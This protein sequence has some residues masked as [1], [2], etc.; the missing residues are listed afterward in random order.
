MFV[1]VSSAPAQ[2]W[3]WN[4]NTAEFLW[5]PAGDPPLP[6]AATSV[7][8]TQNLH[9][10][11]PGCK[12]VGVWGRHAVGLTWSTLRQPVEVLAICTC[13]ERRS[14]TRSRSWFC[15]TPRTCAS[16]ICLSSWMAS[17]KQRSL[18]LFTLLLLNH[19]E[20]M[21]MCFRQLMVMHQDRSSSPYAQVPV[22]SNLEDSDSLSRNSPRVR[23]PL[24]Q[25]WSS[26]IPL[27]CRL[28]TSSSNGNIV[29]TAPLSRRSPTHH[30]EA[31]RKVTWQRSS[32]SLFVQR[33]TY[34]CGPTMPPTGC[35]GVTR[36]FKMKISAFICC[37]VYYRLVKPH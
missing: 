10:L 6:D 31:L 17:S 2:C 15:P 16:G 27:S 8:P 14:R 18:D 21:Q 13:R 34:D 26:L 3:L 11:P 35:L 20:Q 33:S 29:S 37:Y 25:L 1:T 36:W 5:K 28:A 32:F 24:S 19:S 12:A 30:A 4:T 23:L 22:G 9:E 7:K